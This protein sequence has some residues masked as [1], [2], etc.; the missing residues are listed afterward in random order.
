MKS[1]KDEYTVTSVGCV[2]WEE[3]L[4]GEG[5]NSEGETSIF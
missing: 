5:E 1:K 2:L 4:E 3:L